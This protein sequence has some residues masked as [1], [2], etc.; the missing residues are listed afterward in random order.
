M[1]TTSKISTVAATPVANPKR[2]VVIQSCKFGKDDVRNVKFVQRPRCYKVRCK[3]FPV[4]TIRQYA[5]ATT[6]ANAFE[7]FVK[8]ADGEA[9]VTGRTAEAAY[10]KAVRQLWG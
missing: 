8:N 2:V 6:P 9:F 5:E 3:G 10:K 7:A 4:M 1:K